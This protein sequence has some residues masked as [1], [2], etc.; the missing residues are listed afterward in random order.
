M[1]AMKVTRVLLFA[2]NLIGAYT[3]VLV[4]D[5]QYANIEAR[6]KVNNTVSA[7]TLKTWWHPTGEINTKTPV[8]N[9]NVRQSHLYTVQVATVAYSSSYYDSFVYETIP[10]N[11]NGKICTPGNFK[12]ICDTDDQITIEP[13]VGITMAWTQF[14]YKADVVV[15]V[16]RK[17]GVAITASNVIIR[18]TNLGYKIKV[19]AGA[20]LITVP[21][22]KNGVRFS[23]EFKDDIWEYRNAGAGTTSHY[24]QNVAPKGVNYVSSYTSAMP[25]VG[26]EPRNA[27]LIFASAFPSADK[28]PNSASTTLNVKPGLVTGLKTTTKNIVYFGPGVYWFTG[29]AHAILSSSVNWVYFAP[30]AYVKGAIEYKSDASNLKATGYGVLSGEQY[31]YQA[32]T[33]KGYTNVKSDDTSL[34]MWRGT[35]NAYRQTWTVDGVTVNAPPFNSMDFYGNTNG[36][37]VYASDY[38]QVG[39]FFGQTDGMQMYPGS[40][41]HD[42]FYHAGDDVIKTYYSNV[43]AERVVVW[44]TNNA[45]IVQF[46]WYPKTISNITVDHVDVIHS[47]YISQAVPYPRALIGSAASYTNLGSTSTADIN[48]WISGYT[49]SNWRA[50]GISPALL[51]INPLA[52]IDTFSISNVWIEK[53]APETTQV[54][55]STFRPFTDAENGN[56]KIKLGSKSPKA[57]GLT[58]KDYYVGTTHITLAAN[59]WNAGSAGRLNIDASYSGKWTAV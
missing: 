2:I 49:I 59:N 9:G 5:Q 48:S 32:N 44:K 42:I 15:K 27:L 40:H 34:K 35:S 28:I 13:D 56:A 16:T 20:A 22:N 3:M 41:Y 37:S 1:L 29:T 50:E 55:R 11:G 46:G 57:I 33:A 4:D 38:K 31:V 43:L 54:G 39:A 12:T 10:R 19:V 21:Y 17:N 36:L 23:V 45:P 25:I 6:A 8:Q 30:G 7:A 14:L 53:L 18:P 47:R 26:Q 24:V 52:N 58:I 51:G